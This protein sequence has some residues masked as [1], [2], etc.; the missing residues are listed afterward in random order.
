MNCPSCKSSNIL[1]RKA[2]TKRGL[3]QYQCRHCGKYFNERT[4]SPYNFTH[5]PTDVILLVVFFYYRY[6]LSFVDVTEIMALRGIYLS[7]ETVRLWT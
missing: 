1:Q 2:I 7:H 5:Y 3:I 6:K 4:G